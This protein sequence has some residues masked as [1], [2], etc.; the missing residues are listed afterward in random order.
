MKGENDIFD[1]VDF[2]S[3]LMDDSDF[4]GISDQEDVQDNIENENPEEDSTQKEPSK[5]TT[6]EVTAEYEEE[7]DPEKSP[8]G[9]N[10][11]LH[12]FTSALVEAGVLTGVD[13]SKLKIKD[14]AELNEM[15]TAEARKREFEGL[16]EKQKAY[17]EALRTGIPHEEVSSNIET[18]DYLEK[19]SQEDIETNAEL[20]KTLIYNSFLKKGFDK[21]KAAKYTSRS[22]QMEEDIADALEAK[23]LLI[24]EEKALVARKKEEALKQKELAEKQ[25]SQVIEDLKKRVYD[26]DKEVIPGFKPNK[27][28]AD[29]VFKSMTE[30]VGKTDDGRPLNALMKARMENPIEFEH[31]LHYLFQITDGFKDFSYL[32][33]VSKSR[34][35]EE[36][37]AN[38]AKSSNFGGGMTP[39]YIDDSDLMAQLKELEKAL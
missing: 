23:A 18:L 2:E 28:I 37:E 3:M 5:P 6:P 16:N 17:L 20:R 13:P 10:A 38:L 22:I 27:Q 12:S 7:D 8:E 32:K 21:D 25:E 30:I 36:F 33:R 24:D 31:K 35:V 29:K 26:I 4:G 19:I 15:L 1:S 11:L 34:A 14:F 39:S 9:G